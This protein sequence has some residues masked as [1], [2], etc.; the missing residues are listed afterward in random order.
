MIKTFA[1]NEFDFVEYRPDKDKIFG[2]IEAFIKQGG[3]LNYPIKKEDNFIPALKFLEDYFSVDFVKKLIA[4]QYLI[5]PGSWK[6]DEKTSTIKESELYQN[7]W[8]RDN[9]SKY[10]DVISEGFRN[11]CRQYATNPVFNAYEYK[12]EYSSYASENK[13]IVREDSNHPLLS[14]VMRLPYKDIVNVFLEEVSNAKE[15]LNGIYFKNATFYQSL[16]RNSKD[17]SDILILL[18]KKDIVDVETLNN[19]YDFKSIIKQ[20]IYENDFDFIQTL[21]SKSNNTYYLGEL[22]K[23]NS[24]YNSFLRASNTPE[25]AKILI[26]SGCPVVRKSDNFDNILFSHEYFPIYKLDTIKFIMEYVDLNYIKDYE[27]VFWG[28]LE[29]SRD[30]DKFKEFSK[31]I[32]SKGFP[33]EKYDIFN[34]CPGNDWSEK[35]STCI[36][37]GANVDNFYHLIQRLVVARDT[38]T[39]KAI[40]KTKLLNLYSPDGIYH[41]LNVDSHTKST[42]DLLDKA[43]KKDINSLTSFGKPAWFAA[44]SKEKVNKILSKVESFNQLDNNGNNWLTHFYSQDVKDKYQIAPILLEMAAMEDKKNHRLLTLTCQEGKSNLLHYGFQFSEYRNKELREEFVT[45]IKSFATTNINELFDSL[46]ENG[47][48]PTDHLIKSKL[49]KGVWNINSWDIKL[50]NLFKLAEYNLDYDKKNQQG[51]SLIDSIRN[52]YKISNIEAKFIEPVEKAYFRYQLHE[53]LEKKLVPENKKTMR[54]KI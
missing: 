2:E 17:S 6:L 19:E 16:V 13:Y 36:E 22:D 50:D 3:D 44:N 23:E 18:F 54:S 51:L 14:I 39:F 42:L 15:L 33:I 32:V 41:L 12:D 4:K 27:K 52:Y 29:N 25:M 21:K 38:S 8:Y 35:I 31:F 5:S 43:D 53:K 20:A 49:E 28:Y 11:L 45:M 24:M 1:Y 37:L 46:D 34:I 48:F 10:S 40:H 7:Y 9:Y 30:L 47:F 26:D